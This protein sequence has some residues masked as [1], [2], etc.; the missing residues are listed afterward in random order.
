M[1]NTAPVPNTGIRKANIIR[2]LASRL[3]WSW[4]EALVFVRLEGITIRLS[5]KAAAPITAV[6]TK[7]AC[8][9]KCCPTNV[10]IGTPRTFAI[11]NPPRI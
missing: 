5:T 1:L 4:S 10:P 6:R 8:H 7:A 11:P 2:R 9:S 3:S